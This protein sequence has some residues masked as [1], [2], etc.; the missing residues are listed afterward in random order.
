MAV[1][2]K[3]AAK[4]AAPKAVMV[5]HT[6]TQADLDANPSLVEQEI[7]IGDVISID[8]KDPMALPTD[9]VSEVEAEGVAETTPVEM[10]E[11]V[12]VVRG[13][14]LIRLYDS[15]AKVDLDGMVGKEAGRLVIDAYT[16]KKVSVRYVENT[17]GYDEEKTEDFLVSSGEDFVAR[18]I[19]F[20]NSKRDSIAYVTL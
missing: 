20:R 5:D 1:P 15:I 9:P 18:A 11:N 13:N 14:T 4:K 16:I 17:R 10:A 6:V 2:K 19:L 8:Q 7:V 12:A 3:T